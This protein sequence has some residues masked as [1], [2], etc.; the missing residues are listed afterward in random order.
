MKNGQRYEDMEVDD[1]G[2]VLIPKS[3]FDDVFEDF[4]QLVKEM[5]LTQ[6]GGLTAITDIDATHLLWGS[7]YFISLGEQYCWSLHRSEFEQALV[8]NIKYRD[9]VIFTINEA[10]ETNIP[11]P[12]DETKNVSLKNK[13]DVLYLLVR[14]IYEDWLKRGST[15]DWMAVDFSNRRY[16]NAPPS[17]YL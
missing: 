6:Y 14:F 3:K 4:S 8:G 13:D 5:V 16:I 15:Q 9:K 10:G 1:E 2:Y 12:N 11:H 17:P 7:I